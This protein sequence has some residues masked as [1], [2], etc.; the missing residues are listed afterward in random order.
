MPSSD[1]SPVAAGESR[2]VRSTAAGA[3]AAPVLRCPENQVHAGLNGADW[4]ARPVHPFPVIGQ[5][6][7]KSMFLDEFHCRD[8][9]SIHVTAEQASRFAKE[10]AGDY[11]PIHDTD[12][13]RFCVPG[14]L[15]FALVL[16]RYGLSRHMHFRF[17]GM[18]GDEVPLRFPD[19]VG[20]TF[21]I[22]DAAGK[23]YLDIERGGDATDDGAVVEAFI[24][25]YVAFSGRN[26]P[27]FLKPLMA[28]K[29][30]MFNLDRPLVI[31]HSMGFELERLDARQPRLELTTRSLAVEGK[32]GDAWMN[33]ALHE[34]G[35]TIGAGSKKLVM[36]GLRDYDEEA[37]QAF[38]ERFSRRKE[39]Y[40][41]NLAR[42]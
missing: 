10:I 15:L 40:E 19:D 14:D 1:G 6:N 39:A 26:F 29:N 18:V 8:N 32:R 4:I 20:D 22:A 9:G 12:A 24:R 35:D 23:P 21:T 27:H 17:R 28:E 34:N 37:L 42:P 30:V 36:S 41:R 7:T 31:Y 33:F 2:V 38:I 25:Q 11:N 13:K 5:G 16:A 3:G